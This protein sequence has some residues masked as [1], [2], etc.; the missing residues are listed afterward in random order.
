MSTKSTT[1]MCVSTMYFTAL[2][3]TRSVTDASHPLLEREKVCVRERT[4][5]RPIVAGPT[6]VCGRLKVGIYA[7][8]R[9]L[10]SCCNYIT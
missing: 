2:L 8:G 3:F 6:I 4:E 9:A 5:I 1:T 7:E 10:G